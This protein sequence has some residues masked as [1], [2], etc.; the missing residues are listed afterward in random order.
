MVTDAFK[1]ILFCY[2]ISKLYLF[3]TP[4]VILCKAST[5]FMFSV[6][7]PKKKKLNK[8]RKMMNKTNR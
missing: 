8:M 5:N 3:S 6:L 4:A 7:Q 2:F 1:Q